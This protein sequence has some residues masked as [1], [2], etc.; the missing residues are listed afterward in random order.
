MT[1][2]VIVLL[3]LETG[4]AVALTMLCERFSRLANQVHLSLTLR[5]AFFVSEVPSP[6]IFWLTGGGRAQPHF[7]FSAS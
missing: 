4:Y 3:S 7:S 5:R 2:L 6:P 1:L